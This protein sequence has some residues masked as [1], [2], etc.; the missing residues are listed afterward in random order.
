MADLSL[1]SLAEPLPGTEPCG[2]D[3]DLVGDGAYTSFMAAADGLLPA[4]FFSGGDG[5]PFDRATVDFASQYKIIAGLCERTRDLRLLVLLAKFRILDRDITGFATAVEAIAALL[6]RDWE[7]VH[8]RGDHGDFA[9]RMVI[10][11]S[12]DDMVPVILPLSYAPLFEHRH[13]GSVSYRSHL[14]AEGEVAPRGDEDKLDVG[15]IKRAFGEGDLTALVA[16][17][18]QLAGIGA[19][20]A[21]IRAAFVEKVGLGE[22]VAFPRLQPL[23]EKIAAMLDAQVVLRDPSL[24][25]SLPEEDTEAGEAEIPLDFGDIA[26][27]ADARA[28]L[29]A[30]AAYYER[31]E[32]S[33]PALLLVRQAIELVGKSFV[34]ALRVLVPQYVEEVKV[35]IGT[36]QVFDLPIARLSEFASID[37]AGADTAGDPA[38]FEVTSRDT[39]LQLLK[40]IGAFYH[41]AEPSSPVPYLV[42]R[43]RELAGRDF[44]GLLREMLPKDRLRTPEGK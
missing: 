11:Q 35:Q 23:V 22:S 34:D 10:V 1:G 25:V 4:T 13:A 21:R 15:L 18:D 30:I 12:L 2:P 5:R 43:A 40:K 7:A 41:A 44:L 19:A 14:I 39:A 3:L 17:R 27:L 9:F 29:E 16:R 36:T 33:N 26:T 20:L 38:T 42:D 8:P 32:P 28:A 24:G 6:D 31:R 37:G